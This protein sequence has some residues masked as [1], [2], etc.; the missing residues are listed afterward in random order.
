VALPAVALAVALLSCRHQMAIFF[1]AGMAGLALS[2]HALG[3]L[4]FGSAPAWPKALIVLGATGFFGA[5]WRELRRAR[6]NAIEDVAR[7][8]R[9]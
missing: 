6:G 2:I 1:L 7:Q 3:H 4:Y 8:S 9:L 5:L